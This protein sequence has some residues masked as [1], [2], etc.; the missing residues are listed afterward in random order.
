ML[1]VG[2]ETVV[3]RSSANAS[4]GNSASVDTEEASIGC[5]IGEGMSISTIAGRS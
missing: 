1:N 4:G 3:I 2:E 5:K